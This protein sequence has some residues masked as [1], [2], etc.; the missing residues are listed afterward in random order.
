MQHLI[1]VWRRMFVFFLFFF[2]FRKKITSHIIHFISWLLVNFVCVPRLSPHAFSRQKICSH[3]IAKWHRRQGW[4][5]TGSAMQKCL[6]TQKG[7]L[8]LQLMEKILNYVR[9]INFIDVIMPLNVYSKTRT[10]SRRSK[11]WNLSKLCSVSRDWEI[12]GPN[13]AK[14]FAVCPLSPLALAQH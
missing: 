4:G 9:S 8:D 7:P 13:N 2:F 1:L 11:S 14:T 12:W 10:Y 6:T 3:I 5:E